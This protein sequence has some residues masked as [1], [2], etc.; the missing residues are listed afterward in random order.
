MCIIKISLQICIMEMFL[1]LAKNKYLVFKSKALTWY[2]SLPRDNLDLS[3]THGQQYL[4]Y[5]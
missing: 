5:V 3:L 1:I 4:K 2:S